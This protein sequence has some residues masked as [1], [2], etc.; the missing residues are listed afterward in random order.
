MGRKSVSVPG[1]SSW[2]LFPECSIKGQNGKCGK[3]SLDAETEPSVL[4]MSNIFKQ[5]L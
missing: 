4:N 2:G 3:V 5:R 1:R